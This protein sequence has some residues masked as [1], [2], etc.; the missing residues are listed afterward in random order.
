MPERLPGHTKKAQA[1]TFRR[2]HRRLR[3]NGARVGPPARRRMAGGPPRYRPN[4]LERLRDSAPTGRSTR[5]YGTAPARWR[6][7]PS[8]AGATGRS[9]SS[10]P[11]T[12]KP[13]TSRSPG[14]SCRTDAPSGHTG[15]LRDS[16]RSAWLRATG[17]ECS[18]PPG[19][20]RQSDTQPDRRSRQVERGHAHL[21]GSDREAPGSRRPEVPGRGDL[22]RG[23]FV[24]PD[25]DAV[26][27]AG[28]GLLING[29]PELAP[30]PAEFLR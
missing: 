22:P 25:G 30:G 24:V 14:G 15:I 5:C 10:P 20:D 8:P 26:I 4:D 18:A 28:D 2:R 9:G 7:G 12:R 17:A 21:S 19:S 3:T 16:R 13:S 29:D 23:R 27:E 6:C 11:P 1:T